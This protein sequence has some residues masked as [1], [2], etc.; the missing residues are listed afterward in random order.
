MLP[1]GGPGIVTASNA[2]TSLQSVL[3]LLDYL[4]TCLAT[5]LPMFH[6]PSYLPIYLPITYLARNYLLTEIA[7]VF[8][9]DIRSHAVELGMLWR[10]GNGCKLNVRQ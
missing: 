10:F 3:Y 8:E 6:L 9:L 5:Y 2:S 7:T 4:P 1:L